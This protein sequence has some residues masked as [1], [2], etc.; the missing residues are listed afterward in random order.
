MIRVSTEDATELLRF[1]GNLDHGNE[2][3]HKRVKRSF[4][5]EVKKRLYSLF[6]YEGN[7]KAL[8]IRKYKHL[9]MFL[10]NKR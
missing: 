2:G 6:I 1:C 8:N 10:I 9:F 7:F 4:M 3:K 5:Q